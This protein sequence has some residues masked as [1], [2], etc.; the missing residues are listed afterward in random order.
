MFVGSWKS[1]GNFFN[2]KSGNPALVNRPPLAG[3]LLALQQQQQHPV[4]VKKRAPK[5]SQV[6]QKTCTERELLA[7]AFTRSINWFALVIPSR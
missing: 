1:P 4:K 6:Q 2:Q 3:T 7:S 5:T